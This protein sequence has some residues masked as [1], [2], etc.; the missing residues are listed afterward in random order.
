M[1]K[2]RHKRR[3]IHTER[4][5]MVF[6]NKAEKRILPAVLGILMIIINMLMPF[7]AYAAWTY[8]TAQLTAEAGIV[9]DVDTG[10]VLFEKNSSEKLYPASITKI[11]T[12]LVV[13]EHCGLDEKVMFSHD[14]VYNVD[15]GSSN[16]QIDEGDVLTVSDCLYALLLKSANEAA[17][18]LAEHVAGSREAFADMMNAEAIRLGCQNTHF[19]NPSGLFSEDHYTTAYDM[20]LIG[21]AAMQNS[22]FREIDSHTSHTLAATKKVPEG[23]T[24]YMEHKMLLEGTKY[25]D[26][27]VVGGK[28]GYTK[29]TGNT[30]V[31]MA[32]SDGRRLVAV[33]LMDKTPYHYVDTETML[34]LGFDEFENQKV[35]SSIT[36]MDAIRKRLVADTIVSDSC[37][38]S[39]LHFPKNMTVSLPKGSSQD[40]IAYSLN[41]NLRADAPTDAVAEI[42]YL[43]DS[44]VVGKY[45][46]EKE[47][48]IQV[49]LDEVPTGTKV[50][51][52]SVSILT[53]A[54]IAAFF[55]LGGGTAWKIKN[56]R[57][58]FR[59]KHKM[60]EKRKQRLQ[61]LNMT[62]EEFRELVEKKRSRKKQK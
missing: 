59:L 55:I 30:L 61:E 15:A 32:E 18:A 13:L 7:T 34:N 23:K 14:A 33:V 3:E 8:P 54:G 42:Q 53:I 26:A 52:A 44:R 35:D 28:T 31:T 46:L 43:A 17:N 62:E 57:D 58:E 38:V 45:Y 12:A 2:M 51:V 25:Y 48:S 4:G 6:F 24:V 40:G 60:K 5:W 41:Y 50:A 16:A 1:K 22:K 27:R 36:D 29:D 20:A 49:I 10:A 21:A 11:M 47:P 56:L 39:D 9:M 19:S 37:Q